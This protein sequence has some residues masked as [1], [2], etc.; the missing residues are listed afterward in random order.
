MA[1]VSDTI[2]KTFFKTGDKPTA[3]Q[4]AAL[5]DSMVNKLDDAQLLGLR[6]YDP[7][8]VYADGD[9]TLFNFSVYVC[10]AIQTTGTFKP[11]DWEKVAGGTEGGLTY[12]GAWDAENNEPDLIDATP[13]NS[14][15]YVVSIAGD[16]N[17]DGITDWNLGDWAIYNGDFWEKINNSGIVTSGDNYDVDGVGVYGELTGTVLNFKKL[18]SPHQSV[19]VSEDQESR[20]ILLDVNF[21]DEGV[22]EQQ[23]WSS[24]KIHQELKQKTDKVSGA[25]KGN[26]ASLDESGNIQ[27]SGASDKD[28]LSSSAQAEDIPVIPEGHIT[29]DNVQAALE[30]LDEIKEPY[31]PNIQEHIADMENPHQTTKEQVGL[32]NVTNDQQ[33]SAVGRAASNEVSQNDT[34]EFES[35]VSVEFTPQTTGVYIG[36][37]Y[38]ELGSTAEGTQMEARVT[39]NGET[40]GETMLISRHGLVTQFESV[41]GMIAGNLAGGTTYTAEI[42]YRKRVNGT[43]PENHACRIRRARIL[44]LKA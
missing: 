17:L 18:V 41:S 26:F 31:N 38:F 44:V 29:A 21:D 6:V 20:Q 3:S 39:L 9:T 11:E 7:Q 13:S 28:F 2:L 43:P 34:T 8:R 36:Q 22:S 4:F 16:T 5:I 32:G 27:D 12:R 30:E 15:Y 40:I 37:W 19:T 14:D 23:T 35:K 42:L 25:T 33:V 1:I 10:I 24:D